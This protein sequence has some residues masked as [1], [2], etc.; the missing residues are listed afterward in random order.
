MLHLAGEEMYDLFDTFTI[1][2]PGEDETEY[3]IAKKAFQNH[4]KP[5]QNVEFHVYT[6][7]Q[8]KQE[9]NETIDQYYSRL[10]NLAKT[11]NYT[12]AEKEIKTQIIHGCRSHSL[13]IKALSD[14]TMDL[15]SVLSRARAMEM[16]EIQAAKIEKDVTVKEKE[17]VNKVSAKPGNKRKPKK[18]WKD[19]KQTKK[20]RNCGNDWPHEGGQ[21]KCPAFNKSCD[22][23]GKLNH[24][25]KVCKSTVTDESVSSQPRNR[26]RTVQEDNDE[27]E[28]DYT[29]SVNTKTDK[30]PQTVVKINTVDTNMLIDTGATVNVIDEK[31]YQKLN[32]PYL[33]EARKLYPYASDKP[34][35]VLGK[36]TATVEKGN[37]VNQ[38]EFVVVK[39]TGGNLL[40]YDTAVQL[41]IMETIRTVQ[42]S[43]R[44]REMCAKYP[45]VFEG[46]GKIKDVQ[47]HLEVDKTIQPKVSTYHSRKPHHL[48]KMIADEVRKMEEQDLVEE[49][50]GP[51][52]WVVPVI[53]VP[54][55]NG[56]LRLCL[57]M[58]GTNTAIQRTRHNTPTLEDLVHDLN[59]A[60]IFTK[61][62][63]N[64]AYHQIELSPESRYLTT[65][66]SPL[67]LRRYKRLVFGINCASEIFQNTLEQV[68]QGLD[69]VKNMWDDIIVF[70]ASQEEHDSNLEKVL[71]R[72]AEKGITLNKAKCEFSKTEISFF[73]CVFGSEGMNP[74][75]KKVEA[76]KRTKAPS[77]VGEVRSFL[78]MTNYMSR[79]ISN[80]STLAAPLC[81]LTKKNIKWSWT[82]REQSAFD[83]LKNKLTSAKT[84]AYFSKEVP[85]ELIVDGS[86]VGL[87][88]ILVQNNRPIAYGSRALTQVERRYSQTEREALAIVWG[89]RTL[90]HVLI[91]SIVNH[92][93]GSQTNG[94]DL[95]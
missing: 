54:K 15:A 16:A 25:A 60:T 30:S 77:N 34:L 61:L 3:D 79:F 12:E 53:T 11:C 49:V 2:E 31:T 93:D 4:F 38:S 72:L 65:F 76:I 89:Y 59:G 32:K 33:E 42:P 80:Y 66:S 6:F 70:A 81:A 52:P 41:K 48:R 55:A 92:R 37:C 84:L 24:F 40:S 86:P 7:R 74:D 63:M 95:E 8:S 28:N 64:Q 87:G 91:W 20:C 21:R 10:K 26:A 44:I 18:N 69:G 13:R 1:T 94:N 78:G 17:S 22:K 67:G 19:K 56:S 9:H 36:F 58:R 51:T 46:I 43:D 5:E 82:K 14:P 23:C 62:D 68:L 27:S 85:T 71:E 83:T 57:D 73:G 75:P 90:P 47:V 88:A 45:S 35:P 29:F 50:D 39:G